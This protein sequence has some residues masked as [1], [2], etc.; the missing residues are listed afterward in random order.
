M[1]ST[2]FLVI[3][4]YCIEKYIDFLTSISFDGVFHKIQAIF[5]QYKTFSL[6]IKH[7]LTKKTLFYLKKINK[8]RC[9]ILSTPGKSDF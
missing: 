2:S 3:Y 8:N 6:Q 9:E 7:I 1:I 5:I 4:V